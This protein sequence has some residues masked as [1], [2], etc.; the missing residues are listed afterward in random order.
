MRDGFRRKGE[1]ERD[2]DRA[3]TMVLELEG[4]L[5]LD[6][7]ARISRRPLRLLSEAS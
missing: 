3:G 2:G 7:D 5:V 4:M 1:P 6:A